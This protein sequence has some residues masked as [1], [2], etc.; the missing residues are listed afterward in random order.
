ML[1]YPVST[2]VPRRGRLAAGAVLL[3]LSMLVPVS[4]LA[5]AA[6]AAVPDQATDAASAMRFAHDGHK[7]VSVS[8]LTSETSETTA[9]PDGTWTLRTYA[10]PVR[11]KQSGTWQALDTTLVRRA[12]GG[13]GPKAALVDL[14]LSPGG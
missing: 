11:V 7:K 13:I 2:R 4:G 14:T 3:G 1:T 9:N 8:S 6:P 5:S 10:H 12:D